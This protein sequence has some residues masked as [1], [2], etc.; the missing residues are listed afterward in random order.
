VIAVLVAAGT[1][2]LSTPA[3][4][5]SPNI[6]ISAGDVVTPVE[7]RREARAL[8]RTEPAPAAVMH[9]P[10]RH[11]PINPHKQRL[12]GAVEPEAPA[13]VLAPTISMPATIQN[14]AG[15]SDQSPCTGGQCGQGHPPDPNG[16]VGPNHYVQAVN[17][18]IG[19]FSKTG[20]Q[21]AATRFSAYWAGAGTGTSCDTNNNGDP[22]VLYD[23]LAD[24]FMFMDL[25]WLDINTGPFYFCF[26]VAQTSDPLGNYWLY[27]IRADDSAHPWLPDYPKGAVWPDGIYFS[28]NMFQGDTSFK[29]VR[30]WA[31]NR[32]QLEAGQPLQSVVVDLNTTAYDSL[33]PA[34]LRGAPPPAG[35]PN[36]VISEDQTLFAFDVFKFH[37]VYGA[38][39][40]S[41]T[42][43]T[44]VSQASY[45]PPA[46]S[47]VPQPNT[48]T[49]LDT[50]FDRVMMQNQYRTIGGAE[51][52][53]TAHTVQTSS[54]SNT[55]IQW[56]QIDVTA[57]A[58][59]TTPLQQQEYFP[60]STLYRWMPSLAVDRAG[61]MAVGYSISNSSTFPGIRYAGRLTT[62]PAGQLAQGETTLID[63]GGSQIVDCGGPC[64]RWGDYTAMTID[65]VDDCTF[66]YTNEYYAVSGGNWNTRIGSFKFPSCSSGPTP[67]PSPSP[68]PAAAPT[69]TPTRTASSTPTR[70]AT[71]TPTLTP[72]A[73]WTSTPTTSPSPTASA[74]PT[75][76]LTATQ[77]STPAATL[78]PTLT[79]TQTATPTVTPTPTLSTTRTSTPTSTSTQTPTMSSTPAPPAQFSAVQDAWIDQANA[80]QNKGTDTT[81]HVQPVAGK[82][83]RTLVR[84]DFSSV[85]PS[86]CVSSAVLRLTLTA[87]QSTSRTYAVHR[88]SQ[89]W[90]EGNGTANSGVS[91]SR[92]DGVT[93]WTSP[94]GDFN[95]LATAQRATGTTNG[96][97]LEW[98]VTADVAAFVAGTAANDGWLVKDANEGSGGEFRFASRENGTIAKRPQVVITFGPCG[99]TPTATATAAGTLPPTATPTPTAVVPTTLGASQDSWI[100]QA[101]VTQNKGTDANLKVQPAAGKLRRTLV[102]FDLSS[103]PPASCVATALLK[104]R[105]TAVQSTSRT[106]GVYRVTQG[107]TEGTGTTN[108]G[109]TW[110]TRNGV[111]AWTAPGGDFAATATASTAT[112]TTNNVTLQWNVTADVAGFLAG[113]APNNGWLVK[114]VAEGSGNEFRFASRENGTVAARPQLVVTLAPCP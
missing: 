54:S 44:R 89:S 11:P 80:T 113:T 66:W 45:T 41:F 47:I 51:S 38:T 52:L 19:I 21:L 20:T 92:R 95:A 12:P 75:R 25:S 31:F 102:K 50:L 39:G 104:L 8:A 60:D 64:T 65:P 74:T 96:V 37:V 43:P 53:W 56:A 26:A 81:L 23:P 71:A 40:S 88:L 10:L 111:S 58:V 61:D 18:A 67:T 79:V 30:L 3:A 76:T 77:T 72:S 14:F 112:G 107:W 82:L 114:D 59:A 35:T 90:T 36:Y 106:F 105:L 83:R 22:I 91:W 4:A 108:S 103:F 57:G 24:R 86:S 94:G 42:G 28:A 13:A 5:Q 84:F 16:D 68:T 100:D 15:L 46:L 49:K 97:T 33:L 98:N 2:S 85:S 69:F 7:S 27:A 34:N 99:P 110:N 73:T 70:T 32:T 9:R 62:D 17:T 1:G 93:A 87:V 109:V 29:E 55:G 78:T 101:N 63:G 48:T 6:A